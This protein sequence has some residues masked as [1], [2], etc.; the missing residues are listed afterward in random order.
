MKKN[1][2]LIFA[3]FLSMSQQSYSGNTPSKID[4]TGVRLICYNLNRCPCWRD[5]K[6]SEREFRAGITKLYSGLACY[7]TETIRSGIQ[8][9]IERNRS[10]DDEFVSGAKVFAFLRVVFDLPDNY[11]KDAKY[12]GSWGSPSKDGGVNL[13]WPYAKDTDGNLILV[14]TAWDYAG[15]P[16][17]PLMEFDY[18][19]KKYERRKVKPSS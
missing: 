6:E 11:V 7:N 9:F 10:V 1:I 14:G 17:Q 5:I 13:L 3:F 15:P 8:C 18:L 19:Q 16:Y 2:I 12:T 4:E